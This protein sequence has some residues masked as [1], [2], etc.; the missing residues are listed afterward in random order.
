M[1]RLP[2]ALHV[3]LSAI[4]APAG[5][6][7]TPMN[8][9]TPLQE[10]T[11][12]ALSLDYDGVSVSLTTQAWKRRWER[13]CLRPVEGEFPT[14]AEELE[15]DQ[16]RGS[17]EVEAERWRNEGGFRREELSVTRLGEAERTIAF[18][19]DWLELDSPDE[20]IRF[21]SELVSYPT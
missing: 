4:P 18:A 5:G 17:T 12:E 10:L 6:R 19:S 16:Q 7:L 8:V 3:P 14:L 15:D 21:D 11:N 1:P 20:G 9:P 2:V 13:L